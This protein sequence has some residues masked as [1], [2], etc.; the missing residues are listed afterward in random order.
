VKPVQRLCKYP[1]LFKELLRNTAEDDPDFP[2]VQNV[3]N[4]MSDV[5]SHANEVKREAERVQKLSDIEKNITHKVHNF[6]VTR[7]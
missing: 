5:A 1:L 6:A 7:N 3:Y 2:H 4:L